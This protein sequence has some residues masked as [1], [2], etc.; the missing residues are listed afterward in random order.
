MLNPDS[1][2]R[3]ILLAGTGAIGASIGSFLNVCVY[4]IPIGLT[5]TE[6]RRSFCPSCHHQVEARDNIP[7]MSWLWLRGQCRYCRAPISIWYFLVEL[8]CGVG[9][10]LAYLK[11]GIPEAGS[12]L[13]LFSLL[14]IALRTKHSKYQPGALLLIWLACAVSLVLLQR[15]ITMMTSPATILTSAAA[16]LLISSRWINSSGTSWKQKLVIICATLGCG[17]LISSILAAVFLLTKSF[18][19]WSKRFNGLNDALLLAGV[20]VGPLMMF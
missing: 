6:P 18:D 20:C 19:G 10:V 13:L 4:R 2:S 17:G 5:V 12:F 9:A 14:C 16:G 7:V 8:L 3:L 15:Q 1:V 11:G